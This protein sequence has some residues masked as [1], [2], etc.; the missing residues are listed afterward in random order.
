M[1]ADLLPNWWEKYSLSDAPKYLRNPHFDSIW[2]KASP[3]K[4]KVALIGFGVVK[5]PNLRVREA[6]LAE[7]QEVF[8]SFDVWVN[9]DA[10]KLY[11]G[12]IFTDFNE[13]QKL[14]A[15]IMEVY[16]PTGLYSR[17]G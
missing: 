8:R 12:G 13:L 4:Q 6:K 16:T 9:L 3:D 10:R 15:A 14:A 1:S 11:L 17:G 7:L 2:N 5:E